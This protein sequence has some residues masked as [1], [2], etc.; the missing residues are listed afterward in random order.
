ML[1]THTFAF[2]TTA[3]PDQV[4]IAL[5]DCQEISRYLHGVA[6][7][8][9]WLPASPVKLCGSGDTVASG[10]VLDAVRGTRLVLSLDGGHG[11]ATYLTWEIASTPAGT[12]VRLAIDDFGDEPDEETALIWRPILARLEANLGRSAER[13][14]G[15][16]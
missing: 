16:G 8:S 2:T 13:G 14:P 9:D 10:E 3:T 6:L 7:V 4:W 12:H 15:R 11:P 5:T 1:T